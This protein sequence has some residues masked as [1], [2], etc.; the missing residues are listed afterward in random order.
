MKI[1]PL[2][3]TILVACLFAVPSLAQSE[4]KADTNHVAASEP[5]K[6]F[7]AVEIAHTFSPPGESNVR[8]SVKLADGVALIG[9]EEIG[10]VFKTTPSHAM[11]KR[12]TYWPPPTSAKN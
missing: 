2:I 11:G 5:T 1:L 10:D 9:T 8:S 4:K 6:R 7:P 12:I 3:L